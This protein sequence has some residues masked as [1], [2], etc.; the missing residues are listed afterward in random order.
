MERHSAARDERGMS[1]DDGR[2]M[3]DL[4][5]HVDSTQAHAIYNKAT[6]AARM[7]DDPL[8]DRTLDQR[9]ADCHPIL[10]AQ[11]DGEAFGVVPDDGTTRT[12]S[13]GSA[14]SGHPSGYGTGAHA[15]QRVET[16]ATLEKGWVPID[17]IT[18]RII[19]SGAKSV[20]RLLTHP[21][22]GAVLSVGR[23]R[24]KVPKDLRRYL[25]IRDLTCRFRAA[26]LRPNEAI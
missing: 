6:T 2:D 10:L 19:A 23:K 12:S 20:I 8:D 25:Q 26:R 24:Y 7:M 22:T 11:V 5:L 15:P 14:E 4:I 21:E 13:A 1:I 3:S 9:R 18:A 17:P 16:P